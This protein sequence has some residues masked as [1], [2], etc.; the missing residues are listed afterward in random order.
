MKTVNFK[1]FA[2]DEIREKELNC[3]KGGKGDPVGDIIVPPRK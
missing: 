3:L 2:K 1:S